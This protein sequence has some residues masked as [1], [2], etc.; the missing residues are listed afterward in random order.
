MS[1]LLWGAVALLAV[2]LAVVLVPAGP[3]GPVPEEALAHI[4]TPTGTPGPA[5]FHV[6]ID[7]DAH[8]GNRPC[9]PVDVSAAAEVGERHEVAVCIT[10]APASV[11]ALSFGLVY[12]S[13]LDDCV[14]EECAEASC[15]DGNPDANLGLTLGSGPTT[16]PDLGVDGDWSC[17]GG[18]LVPPT[19][20]WPYTADTDALLGCLGQTGPYTSPVDADP[21][22]LAVVTF[23]AGSPGVDAL[24]LREG[25]VIGTGDVIIGTCNG[26][27][28][29]PRDIPCFG[30]TV[31]VQSPVGGI[32]E[33]PDIESGAA[34]SGSG[35][36][37]AGA[38]AAVTAGAGLLFMAGAWYTRRR[39]RAG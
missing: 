7:A 35:A 2:I 6:E 22:P 8:N 17:S 5:M 12:D 15:L 18:G 24:A 33:A 1:R 23:D 14:E 38:V 13:T 9:D 39:R 28:P 3:G 27:F 26:D 20:D 30:A 36:S 32:A 25:Y 4:I 29:Y 34:A 31:V 11:M 37:V 16:D 19:C 21:W 10:D